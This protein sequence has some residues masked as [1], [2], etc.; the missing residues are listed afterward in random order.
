MTKIA[1]CFLVTALAVAALSGCAAQAADVGASPVSTPATI[2]DG[3]LCMGVSVFREAQEAQ[4]PVAEIGEPGRT[5]LAEAV[6][7]DG[8]PINIP[9][10]QGWYLAAMTDEYVAVMREVD[11]VPDDFYGPV[12]PDHDILAVSWVGDA[13]NLE[14]GWY[15]SQS[16]SCALSVDLGDLG[17]P[18]LQLQSPTEPA[19]QEL[20]L[21]VTEPACN[22]GQD[23]EGRIEVVSIE[24]SDE[25]VAVLLGVRP[26]G[27]GQTCP[28]NPA[29][30]FTVTLAEPLGSR[31][32]VDAGLA[33]KRVVA[34]AD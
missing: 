21:L 20:H 10:N 4:V 32:V 30:P 1:S 22:S 15:G 18:E 12:P 14:P 26:R 6:W 8:T 5:A 3:F 25:R 34:P 23:A 27:G 28:S 33:D 7:D 17:V 31:E 24:E 2:G 29:T 9:P 16:S 13:T 11:A 19:S